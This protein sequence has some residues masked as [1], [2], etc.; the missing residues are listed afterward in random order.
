MQSWIADCNTVVCWPYLVSLHATVA[1]Q[2]VHQLAGRAVTA[3]L[4]QAVQIHGIVVMHMHMHTERAG[5]V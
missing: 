2:E 3:H 1:Q 4:Q 5:L